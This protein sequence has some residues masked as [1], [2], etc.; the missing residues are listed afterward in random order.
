M[1]SFAKPV[2]ASQQQAPTESRLVRHQPDQAVRLGNQ[3][4]LHRLSAMLPRVQPKLE[5]GGVNDPLE[6]EADQVADRVMRMAAPSAPITGGPTQLSRRCAACE[7]AEQV[8]RKPLAGRSDGGSQAPA[9]VHTALRGPGTPL[10]HGVRGFFEPRFGRDFSAVRIHTDEPAAR[11]AQ[12]V[13]ALAYT[14]GRNIVFAPGGYRPGTADGSRLLAHELVHV[15]QQG[16][17]VVVRRVT[18]PDPSQG[19][20]SDPGSPPV[21]KPP[22]QATDPGADPA[23]PVQEAPAADP[24]A[25]G[26]TACTDGTIN[27]DQDPLPT[28]PAFTYELMSGPKLFEAVTAREPSITFHPLGAS[29]PVFDPASLGAVKVSTAP[30]TGN[31]CLKCVADWALPVPKWESFVA[32]DY[33]V[34]DEPKRRPAIREGDTS[35]CRP[36]S[37]PPLTEVRIQIPPVLVPKVIAGER[38]HYDD[39]ARAY[40]ISGGRH[41][42]NMRRLTLERTH[43]RGHDQADCEAKVGGFIGAVTGGADAA[44]IGLAPLM[45]LK[46]SDVQTYYVQQ[47]GTALFGESFKRVYAQTGAR[48]ANGGPHHAGDPSPPRDRTPILPN[49]DTAINPFG[50]DAYARRWNAQSLPGVPGDD[51]KAVVKDLGDPAKR[52][53]HVL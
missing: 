51:A 12:D 32:N 20:G 38:E 19:S 42:S 11:S 49:L 50:C 46:P 30:D 31:Q 15:V 40:Q 35:G 37:L 47:F 39:F 28:A 5:I 4:I 2:R 48:D 3:A 26:A 13:G 14:V 44:M 52:P 9:S 25:G 6:H 34:S 43:L 18:S 23:A 1:Q 17:P 36:N 22:E 10:S 7:E 53:W 16:A 24:A 21:S 27:Q 41:L 45:R 29:R 33:V 8:Q